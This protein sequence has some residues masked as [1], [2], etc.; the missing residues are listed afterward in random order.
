MY[1]LRNFIQD[2]LLRGFGFGVILL[3][4]WTR[5]IDF[6]DVVTDDVQEL[7][8]YANNMGQQ[9]KRYLNFTVFP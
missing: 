2:R 5:F 1:F 8:T 6:I 9:H 4:L 3:P 7:S